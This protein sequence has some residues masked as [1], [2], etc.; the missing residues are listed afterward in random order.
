MFSDN[1]VNAE[2]RAKRRTT[3]DSPVRPQGAL[4]YDQKNMEPG[5][6]RRATDSIEP[7]ISRPP[8]RSG[9]QFEINRP[10]APCGRTGLSTV[11]LRFAPDSAFCSRIDYVIRKTSVCARL[12]RFQPVP[13]V[14]T[15]LPSPVSGDVNIPSFQ[16]S[17]ISTIFPTASAV[18]VNSPGFQAGVGRKKKITTP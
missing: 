3:L 18:D 15:F 2:S 13:G 17:V 10:R 1:N 9:L 8:L 11:V 4:G 12:H 14:W 5:A 16:G 7:T 6:K